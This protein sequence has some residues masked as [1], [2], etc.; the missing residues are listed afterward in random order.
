VG[1]DTSCLGGMG[2]ATHC[3]V[4]ALLGAAG[5]SGAGFLF[6]A[7]RLVFVAGAF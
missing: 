7:F 1:G 4:L 3:L 5:T 2:V 6:L